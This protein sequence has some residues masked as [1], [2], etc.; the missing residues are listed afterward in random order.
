MQIVSHCSSVTAEIWNKHVSSITSIQTTILNR[1]TIW[2]EVA[3]PQL[4]QVTQ[5]NLT[6]QNKNIVTQVSS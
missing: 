3:V 2:V 1:A 5:S 4:M 6:K